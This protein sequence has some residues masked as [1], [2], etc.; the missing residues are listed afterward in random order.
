MRD[1]KFPIEGVTYHSDERSQAYFNSG[2]WRAQTVG[3]VLRDT[4]TRCGER[5]ALITDQGTLTFAELD[6]QSERLGAA[7]LDIGLSPGDRAKLQMGTTLETAVTLLACYKA[8]IIPVCSLPQHRALE[9]GQLVLQSAARGYFVQA[10]FG[11]FDL[12]GFAKEMM[13][14]HDSL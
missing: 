8:G 4:A 1:I 13:R 2:A 3:Q 5:P 6:A 10:D 7:L 14:S 11:S 12:V 9:I